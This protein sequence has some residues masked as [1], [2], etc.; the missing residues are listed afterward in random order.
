[1]FTQYGEYLTVRQGDIHIPRVDAGEPLDLE[2]R[3]FI[4]C[5]QSGKAPHSGGPSALKVV[6]L[7][8]AASQSLASGGKPVQI[9]N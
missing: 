9:S 6:E 2:C 7:L 4:D 8:E 5:I 3:H 1:M